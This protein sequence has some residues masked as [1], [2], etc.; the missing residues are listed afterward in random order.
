MSLGE[1]YE[2]FQQ[3]FQGFIKFRL[4]IDSSAQSKMEEFLQTLK[5]SNLTQVL[6][7]CYQIAPYKTSFE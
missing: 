4:L 7:N 6:N 5:D 2:I 1:A 3:S